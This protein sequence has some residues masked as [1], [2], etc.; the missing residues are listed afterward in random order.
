MQVLCKV[1]DDIIPFD[2]VREDS[3]PNEWKVFDH[4]QMIAKLACWG[5]INGLQVWG[6][7]IP[8]QL[9]EEQIYWIGVQIS[10]SAA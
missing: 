8:T 9:T 6:S 7:K 4:L 10:A 2:V 5:E 3:N 1:G